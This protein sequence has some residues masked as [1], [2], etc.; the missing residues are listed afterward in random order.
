MGAKGVLPRGDGWTGEMRDTNFYKNFASIALWMTT[1][2]VNKIENQ[3]FID[4]DD[5]TLHT[6]CPLYDLRTLYHWVI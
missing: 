6:K 4:L 2:F 5:T 1:F 3:L